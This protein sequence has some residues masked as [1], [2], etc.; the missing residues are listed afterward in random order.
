MGKKDPRMDAYIERSADFAKPVLKHFRNLVHKTCPDVEETMKWSF[1]HFD[2]KGGMM[3]SMASFKQ[4]CA[5]SFWKASLMKD[6]E[7]LI[8]MAKSE[9]AMRHLG[10]ITSLKDLP[11]DPVLAKYIREAMK[12][13]EE[14]IKL[15]PK[16]KPAAKKELEIPAY[17][18]KAL[19]KNKKAMKTFEEFSYTNKKEY[20]LWITEAKS[21]KTRNSRLE[22]AIEWMSEGKIRNW[23]YLK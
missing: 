18:T 11:K 1:P 22:T 7:K 6:S 9:E 4:H 21:E 23:K 17:F 10:R 3:C 5:I 16:A 14:G 19:S 13:N 12:M 20:V 15:S 2:Y 8:G